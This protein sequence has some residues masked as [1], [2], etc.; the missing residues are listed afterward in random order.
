MKQIE[1]AEAALYEVAEGA[2]E[3]SEAESFRGATNRALEMIETAINSGGHVSGKTTGFASINDKCGGLH[4]SDLIIV[5][6]RPGMG[7]SS[8]ATNIAFNC[9]DRLLR[10]QAR[11]DRQV[12]RRGRGHVQPRDVEPTSSPRA[13]S[14]SRRGSPAKRCA[15]ARSAARISSSSSYA[16]QRLAELPLYIDDTP[17]LT[18]GALRTR[19]RRLKR[20]HDIGLIVIDYLQLLQGSGR[21]QDNRVNEISEISRGLKTLAK[22]LQVAGDRAV[23]AQP[24]GRKPRGQAADAADL[25]ESGSIEQ[26]ADMVWFIFRED[27]YVGAR[28]P[29]VPRGDDDMKTRRSPRRMAGSDGESLRPRRA[30]H[31]QAAPRRDR[32]SAPALRAQDHQVQRPR[33]GGLPGQRLRLRPRASEEN[34]DF[35]APAT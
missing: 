19:A 12:G 2:L 10:D 4:N 29:K 6:G 16:S 20:R 34:L 17:A 27:Y 14:P 18:I 26:D 7:K 15:W 11:R 28:E 23:A 3:G 21:S 8:L 1:A 22:E 25:R 35:A 31:R 30:D 32:Q 9:A 24:R 13:S 5:A 33:R